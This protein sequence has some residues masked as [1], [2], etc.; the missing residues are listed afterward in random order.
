MNSDQRT[1]GE[2][3]AIVAVLRTRGVELRS[4]AQYRPRGDL[5]VT[6]VK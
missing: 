4:G 3:E 5:N 6:R 2:W 1:A